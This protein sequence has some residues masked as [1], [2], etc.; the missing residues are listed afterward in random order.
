MTAAPNINP[1]PLL[2][3]V[4]AA[5]YRG[6]SPKTLRNERA[7]GK[8]PRYIRQGGHIAY[9]RSD[10]ERYLEA[11]AVDP[12]AKQDERQLARSLTAGVTRRGR[13]SRLREIAAEFQGK[14]RR[15]PSDRRSAGKP[16]AS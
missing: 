12:S 3:E 7:L 2:S 16:S 13:T 14:S 15:R 11:C 9:R 1:D 6:L 4:Q 8:G 10:L 5:A